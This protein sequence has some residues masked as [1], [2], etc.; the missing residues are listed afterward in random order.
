MNVWPGVFIESPGFLCRGPWN[1][2]SGLCHV[3]SR[4]NSCQL[5]IVGMEDI[6]GGISHD[7]IRVFRCRED[8]VEY[9]SLLGM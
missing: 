3:T 7:I 1:V 2:V 5:R 4:E 9:V 8:L 6:C